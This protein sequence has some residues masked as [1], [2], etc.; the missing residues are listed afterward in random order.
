MT[1]YPREYHESLKDGARRSARAIVPVVI[2]LLAPRSVV[3]VGCGAGSWL[4]V[5][6]E[7][8]VDDIVG[9][10]GPHLDQNVLDIPRHRFVTCD[11]RGPLELA[12]TF[13]LVVCLEVAE[14]LPE[15]SADP[16]ISSLTSLGP[17]VLFS[18]AI[19]AQG[20]D[21]HVN[22]QWPNYWAALFERWSYVP[23][24]CIRRRVWDHPEVEWWYAQNVLLFVHEE[25][26]S[27]SAVLGRLRN[28]YGDEQL[29]V[30]HPNKYMTLLEH[31]GHQHP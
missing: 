17:A 8:G 3:D 21:G 24:D 13:D 2:D 15:E 29:S 19:P 11:L 10:D 18:A 22:E 6:L 14:H 20:G 30:V 16:L 7:N 5:F 23:I 31:T 25:Y 12:R 4:A 26:L 1:D 9:V 27:K 28:Q